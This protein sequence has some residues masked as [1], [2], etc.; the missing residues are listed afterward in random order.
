MFAKKF[1]MVCSQERV[2]E[3]ISEFID[4]EASLP[5]SWPGTW[6]DDHPKWRNRDGHPIWGDRDELEGLFPQSSDPLKSKWRLL[7]SLTRNVAASLGYLDTWSI[8]PKHGPGVVSDGKVVKFNFDNWPRK[9][10]TLFPP[11]FFASHDFVDRTVSDRELPS[12]LACVPKTQKGPRLIACEP[13]AH[14][15]IQGGLQR[16]FEDAIRRHPL[17]LSIDFSNQ[18]YSKEMAL[19]ASRTGNFCTVDLSAASDRLSTRLVE[20]IFQSNITILDALHASR[21]RLLVIPKEITGEAVDKHLCLS[22]FAPMGSA[23][24]FPVQ[25]VVFTILSHFAIMVTEGDNDVSMEAFRKRSSLVR[26]FGD[27]IIVP[28]H[29]YPVLRQILESVLLRVNDSKSYHE[30]F[31]REACGLDAYGGFDVTP[32]Y[33]RNEY[34]AR[35]PASMAS[36]IECSNNFYKKGLWHSADYLLKTVPESERKLLPV[37]RMDVGS[38]TIFTFGK[39]SANLKRRLNPYLQ[40]EEYRVLE[41]SAINQRRRGTG[42]ASLFQYFTEAPPADR[43]IKWE[44]GQAERPRLRKKTRWVAALPTA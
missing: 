15:W 24:T 21:S 5:R 41:I 16:W 2:D 33:L 22:K 4:V 6:D 1:N 26:V 38:C 36:V 43:M 8:R 35:D 20:Y 7:H 9:L 25:T 23:C 27:D 29:V 11:D 42:E 12:R 18:E 39:D 44:S 31:F 17:G 30:G 19:E 13:T 34:N 40:R 14:Q 10:A 37:S 32:A 3:T 28:N